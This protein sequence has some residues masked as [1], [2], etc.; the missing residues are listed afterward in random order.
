VGVQVTTML[1][2]AL[3]FAPSVCNAS[4][5][6]DIARGEAVPI[7]E[8]LS[9]AAAAQAIY[10]TATIESRD[11]DSVAK[12]HE[13]WCRVT[14]MFDELCR[15]WTDVKT[16]LEQIR[17]LLA[18]LCR[19]RD[20]AQDH[21]EIYEVTTS[22]RRRHTKIWGDAEVEYSFEHRHGIEAQG[23]ADQSSPMPTYSLGQIASR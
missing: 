19:Y 23:Y 12:C 8:I 4:L 21:A 1:P 14:K 15:A 7:D 10:L 11:L 6:E 18:R 2:A 16:D 13:L 9:L 3:D 5:R 20:L 22:Q 17:W